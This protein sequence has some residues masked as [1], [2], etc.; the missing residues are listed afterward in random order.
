[1]YVIIVDDKIMDHQKNE[2][3]ESG[4]FIFKEAIRY[5]RRNG[6]KWY[7]EHGKNILHGKQA[8]PKVKNE[9]SPRMP[10]KFLFDRELHYQIYNTLVKKASSYVPRPYVI[11][12]KIMRSLYRRGD[13][14]FF[15]IWFVYDHS[16]VHFCIKDKKSKLIWEPAGSAADT[17]IAQ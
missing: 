14:E 13:A 2:V 6:W 1:M 12:K 8:W 11:T 10:E 15:G 16:G 5:C 9:L 17:C 3:L 7:F 4:F